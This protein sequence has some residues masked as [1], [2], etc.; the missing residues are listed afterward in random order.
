MIRSSNLVARSVAL[1]GGVV[2]PAV[3]AVLL[4]AILGTLT[5]SKSESFPRDVLIPIAPC[6][7][8][9]SRAGRDVAKLA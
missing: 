5:P 2:K 1:I 3:L 8:S 6:M 9:E 4:I 7:G